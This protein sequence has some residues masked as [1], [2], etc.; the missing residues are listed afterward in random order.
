VLLA[1]S[2][3]PVHEPLPVERDNLENKGDT[4]HIETV[5]R[6]R[7]DREGVGEPGGAGVARERDD[8]DKAVCSPDNNGRPFAPLLVPFRI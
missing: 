3:D 8:K 4:L 1:D 6:I 2:A 7:E 5:M